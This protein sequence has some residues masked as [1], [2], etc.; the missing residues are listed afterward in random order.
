MA[1]PAPRHVRLTEV[2]CRTAKARL[3]PPDSASTA[4]FYFGAKKVEIE[5]SHLL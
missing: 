5:S 2:A 4:A 3:S 1:E